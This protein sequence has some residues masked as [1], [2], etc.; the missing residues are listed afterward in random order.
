MHIIS[1]L[2]MAL[3]WLLPSTL[4]AADDF[5]NIHR[6]ALRCLGEP[7]RQDLSTIRAAFC[8]DC[9][10]QW[11]DEARTVVTPYA[12]GLAVSLPCPLGL[13]PPLLRLPHRG[14][15]TSC[16]CRKPRPRPPRERAVASYPSPHSSHSLAAGKFYIFCSRTTHYD[17]IA[18]I[19]SA[20]VS[21]IV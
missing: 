3:L 2:A 11:K 17:N 4:A 21:R 13:L 10:T 14:R 19:P 8:S 12:E 7:I 1:L 16:S 15:I 18:Y 5:T 20:I 9:L 6:D